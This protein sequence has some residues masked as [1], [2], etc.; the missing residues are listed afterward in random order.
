[1]PMFTCLAKETFDSLFLF[2]GDNLRRKKTHSC[3]NNKYLKIN[4][5]LSTIK[6]EKKR[7]HFGHPDH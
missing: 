1:M 5:F 4:K 3:F 6:K 7:Y 2:L